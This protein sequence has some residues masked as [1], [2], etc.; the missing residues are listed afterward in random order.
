VQQRRTTPIAGIGR[1]EFDNPL[2]GIELSR[3]TRP[4]ASPECRPKTDRERRFFAAALMFGLLQPAQQVGPLIVEAPNAPVRLASVRILNPAETPLVLL[5]EAQNQTS[6]TAEQFMVT[7]YIF[8]ETGLRKGSQT[9]PGR[10]TLE[11]KASKYSAMVV[12]GFT[13]GPT[14]RLVVG[15]QQVQWVSSGEWWRAP[16]QTLAE[17]KVK[18]M[19][20]H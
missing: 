5:Y 20:K 10:R 16:L 14:D 8:D 17:A 2:C 18:E 19:T 7:V 9:A 6:D 3:A 11:P 13:I 12:D 15:V 1:G 4:A